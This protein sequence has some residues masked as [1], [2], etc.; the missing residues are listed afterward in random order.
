[1]YYVSDGVYGSFI[2]ELL[3]IKA[4]HPVP[5]NVGL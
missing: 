2:E 4:R 5:L 1:M 3:H